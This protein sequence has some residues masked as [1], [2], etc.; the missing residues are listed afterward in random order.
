MF[1][2]HQAGMFPHLNDLAMYDKACLHVMSAFASSFVLSQRLTQRMGLK[3]FSACVSMSSLTQYKL[4]ANVD[5][6][7]NAD[8]KCEQSLRYVTIENSGMLLLKRVGRTPQWYVSKTQQAHR[9]VD[10]KWHLSN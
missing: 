10:T 3:P 5:A 6:D 9:Y 1:K 2:I 8:I 4:D 7:A